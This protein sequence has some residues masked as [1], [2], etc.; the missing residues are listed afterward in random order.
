MVCRAERTRAHAIPAQ[1]KAVGVVKGAGI[2]TNARAGTLA[3]NAR[4]RGQV[5]TMCMPP[6]VDPAIDFAAMENFP[7]LVEAELDLMVAAMSCG[8]T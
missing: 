1:A 6:A 3:T 8:L 5:T 4:W 2:T 7:G